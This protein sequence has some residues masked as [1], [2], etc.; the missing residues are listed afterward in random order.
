[1][2]QSAIG[3]RRAWFWVGVVLLSISAL[4]WLLIVLVIVEEPEDIASTVGVGLLFSTLP[5]AI[6][7]FCVRR[8]RKAHPDQAEQ[9][10][11]QANRYADLGQKEEA[12]EMSAVNEEILE[13]IDTKEMKQSTKD[14]E[15]EMVVGNSWF[16]MLVGSLVLLIGGTTFIVMPVVGVIGGNVIILVFIPILGLPVVWFGSLLVFWKTKVSFD[17]PPGYITVTRGHISPLLWFLR[18][19]I[20]S[21]EEA[22]TAHYL[23]GVRRSGYFSEVSENKYQVKIVTKSGKEVTLHSGYS[24]PN[25]VKYLAQ[26]ILDFGQQ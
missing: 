14:N 19:K 17:K 10:F 5:I 15:A 25:K 22:R 26:R 11:E 1:M 21:K 16:Y 3:K 18:T 8:G 12:R 7:I 13:V 20:I 24:E 6:G 2:K 9:Y 23:T 4:W